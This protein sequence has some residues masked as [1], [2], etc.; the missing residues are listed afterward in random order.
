MAWIRT[1]LFA[2]GLSAIP[3]AAQDDGGGFLENQLENLLSGPGFD[4]DVQGFQGALSSRATMDAII[5]SDD[6]GPWLA[7]RDAVLDWNRLALLRGRLSVTELA[8]GEI[9][10]ARLPEGDDS[11]DVPQPEAEP[12]SLPELPVSI[13]IDALNVDRLELGEPVLGM[14]VV[15][16]LTGG[17]ELAGGA[18]AIDINAERIDGE[19]GVL[20]LEGSYDNESRDLAL[21]L[22]LE[23]GDDGIV[24]TLL[25]LPGQPPLTASV[26]GQGPLSDFS[27]TLAL[28]TDG[29][30]R[31]DGTVTLQEGEDGANRFAADLGGDV[32]ALFS[33][34]YRPFFGSDVQ[35][36]A[37]GARYPDGRVDVEALN[38][39]A[40]SIRLSGQVAIG[41]D[42][43]PDLIDVEG[44]VAEADGPVL[45]PVGEQIRVGRVGLDVQFDAAQGETWTGDVVIE[46][47]DQPGLEIERLALNGR[48]AIAGSG[49]TL[50]VTANLDFDGT[51]IVPEAEGVEEALG[52]A[53]SGRAEIGYEAGAPIVLQTL[54]LDGAGFDLVGEG[55]FDPAGENVPVSLAAQLDAQDLAV[56]AAL[57]GRPIEG[58]LSADLD[59]DATLQDGGFDV[60]LSGRG[61]SLA[62]GIAELDPLL[63][64]ATVLDLDA[65]RDASG[66]RVDRLALENEALNLLATADLS[67][68]TGTAQVDL[69]IDDLARIDD[70]LS[71]PAVLSFDA[72]KPADAWNVDAVVTGGEAEI[73]ADVIVDELEGD[74]PRLD[75]RISV[76]AADLSNFS[77]FAGRE[78]GGS[79]DLGLDGQFRTDLSAADATLEGTMDDIAIGQ[80]ELDRLLRGTTDIAARFSKDGTTIRVPELQVENPQLSVTGM[81]DVVPQ[82]STVS[83]RA[84]IRNLSEIVP[85]MSGAAEMSLRAA[86]DAQGWTI[87]LTGGGAGA[88]IDFDGTVTE[89]ES[90]A[91]PLADGRLSL[92]APD[93]A[94]FSDLVDRELGGAV[95]LSAEGNARFDLS[96]AE[97]EIDATTTDLA[98]GQPELDRLLDGETILSGAAS[99]AGDAIRV[100]AFTLENP[101]VSLTA[102]GQYGTGDDALQANIRFPELGEIVPAMSGPGTVSLFGEQIDDVWQ[103]AFDADG[104][105]LVADA[106]LDVIDLMSDDVPSASGDV[107]LSIDDLSRFQALVNQDIAGS[108]DLEAN[109]SGT[110]D[111]SV[112]D[113]FLQANAQQLRSGI[114]EVDQLLQG[115]TSLVADASREGAE[116]PIVVQTFTLDAA[117]LDASAEGA[118]LGGDSD[119]TFSARLADLG[120]FV[121]GIDGPVT[122]E[123]QAGQSG[124]D[125]TLDISVDGPQG[126]SADVSG[127]VAESFER[128]NL[129]IEGDAPLRLANPFVEPRALSGT[130]NFDLGLD[131]PLELSSL[132]GQIVV[133][134]GRF[135]DPSLPAV[136]EN[137]QVQAGIANNQVNIE[138]SAAKQEGGEIRASGPISLQPGYTADLSIVLDNVAL[139]DP[140]LYR[141]TV[142]GEISVEGPLTGGAQI[143]GTIRVGE[144]EI[145]V[146][147]TGLG[148]TGPIPDNLTHVN[149]PADVRATRRRAGLIEEGGSDGS[150]AGGGG[151]GVAYP[152]NIQVI[153]ENRIFIR[154]RGLDAELGGELTIQGTTANVIPAGQFELI[155][156]RLDILGQRLVLTEGFVN[157]QGDFS[158]VIRLVAR[159]EAGDVTALIIVQGEVTSPE[160]VFQSE[161]ELPEDEVLSRL[162]FGRSIDNISPLQAA[163]LASAV[164]TLAGRGG[165]GIIANLRQRTGLDDLDVTTDAD[166]NVGVR[167]GRYISDNV[168]T[169]VTVD[170]QGEADINLN[171]DVTDSITVRGGAGNG[172][173][174]NLGVFFERDY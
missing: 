24:A 106:S 81:A 70:G 35:F 26:E 169:D 164:A 69:R 160:I 40:Q 10:L 173:D 43:V 9:A 118:I 66:L 32:T 170:A 103:V 47:L 145:R 141:T 112:F 62:T 7:V 152:L 6:E 100:P 44:E 122:A 135:V 57:A 3:V 48:G 95:D 107:A 113:L 16:T 79:V 65:I 87:D 138:A 101:Q 86:E 30:P 133:P 89:L 139:E 168:Y 13:Q 82:D 71:G 5:I 144:T 91:A 50:S 49:D 105:G 157:L 17:A 99:K 54:T 46:A 130:A 155:R 159:T 19:T 127:S 142:D 58:A 111:G 90:E 76:A 94:V 85:D 117:G 158:P 51:G 21:D 80:A 115:T 41:A 84:I 45:L 150:D 93:L 61:E 153:A 134:D 78:L 23:E 14:P 72:D 120:A 167:A 174:T 34:E 125:F 140:R 123:G 147:S 154:G 2:L 149:E 143:G 56:F 74:A 96:Q 121:P 27:A 92:S 38:L 171:L 64:G 162:L 136:L 29:E 97:A 114:A 63:V 109:G 156:G 110:F 172:G 124:S 77:V 131:G 28:A 11:V 119:L 67:S 4:V 60:A 12:F 126:I 132:S 108:V 39:D 18:G 163:Q 37:R 31:L 59:L 15:A 75:G 83:A 161:P 116:A 73:L 166:G 68:E 25:D 129:A 52:D 42:G 128:A 146:P 33:P 137:L 8:A 102:E 104:A 53:L 148:A 22:A 88:S 20:S 151:G 165:D 1:S 55:R 36:E 98:L